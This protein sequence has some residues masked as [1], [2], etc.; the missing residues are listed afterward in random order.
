MQWVISVSIG[1]FVLFI[2][3]L[4]RFRH[5]LKVIEDHKGWSTLAQ[6]RNN[7]AFQH[8]MGRFIIILGL[9]IMPLSTV[10]RLGCPWMGINI[11]ALI[12][13]IIIYT[14]IFIRWDKQVE[15]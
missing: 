7:I 4:I 3:F 13:L 6:M 10:S 8:T 15:K 14:I 5:I 11:F 2:G 12:A 1:I 9:L